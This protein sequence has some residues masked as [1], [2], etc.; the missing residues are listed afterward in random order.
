[1]QKERVNMWNK[2]YMA[3]EN[4]EKVIDDDILDDLTIAE[5]LGIITK[6]EGNRRWLWRGDTFAWLNSLNAHICSKA[7]F[8]QC[9]GAEGCD[10]CEYQY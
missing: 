10:K 9:N 7:P 3:Y 8:P 4:I 2:V 6:S 1:M 5:N